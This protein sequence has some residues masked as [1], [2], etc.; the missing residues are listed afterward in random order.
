M[1]PGSITIQKNRIYKAAI[2]GTVLPVGS[3]KIRAKGVACKGAGLYL[4]VDSPEL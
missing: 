4:C 3:Y 1:L 2:Y